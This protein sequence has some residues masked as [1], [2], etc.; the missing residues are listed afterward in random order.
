MRLR[1]LK[2][3]FL[4]ILFTLTA[5]PIIALPT[6]AHAA[7][8]MLVDGTPTG[9]QM[10]PA[11]SYTG[12]LSVNMT[13]TRSNDILIAYVGWETGGASS[14][15]SQTSS[16]TSASGTPA[17]TW[18]LRTRYQ[19]GGDQTQEIWWAVAPTAGIYGVQINWIAQ[20][21]DDAS[22]ALFAI[23]GANLSS[24]WES[25]P[26]KKL[27][28]GALSG[29][30]STSYANDFVLTFYGNEYATAP[31]GP[32]PTGINTSITNVT[33][34]GARWWEYI[35]VA[36]AAVTAPITNQTWGWGTTTGQTNTVSAV[37]ID[38][39]RDAN[40]VDI[41]TVTFTV[42]SDLIYRSTNSIQ[43]TIP[44]ASGKVTFYALGKPIVG[45]KNIK[46]SGTNTA[47]CSWKNAGHGSVS[48]YVTFISD[49]GQ[50]FTSPTKIVNVTKRLN[51]R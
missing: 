40:Y 2:S 30:F 48:L 37:I 24:P 28:L 8:N 1:K 39:L 25:A 47:S 29:S 50:Q 5:L 49:G 3:C 18:N 36:G 42:N 26:A 44:S 20:Y 22:L 11:V 16:V 19:N 46:V 31:S 12:S 17:L 51:T 23:N 9:N 27:P 6:T 38:A 4:L 14:A 10:S 35:Y 41:N 45:C 13:T 7:N 21:I 34:G 15:N 43:A 32:L 33:N